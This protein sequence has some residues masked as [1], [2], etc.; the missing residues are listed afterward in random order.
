[1][2]EEVDVA[3]NPAVPVHCADLVRGIAETDEVCRAL[4]SDQPRAAVAGRV[5]RP[6]GT[7]TLRDV[8]AE[9]LRRAILYA[10]TG[11]ITV[12]AAEG[13]PGS[14]TP[15]AVRRALQTLEE[16]YL[17]LY[18]SPRLVINAD[19]FSKMARTD[20]GVCSGVLALTTNGRLISG[21]RDWWRR[22]HPD[23]RRY[24]DGAVQHDGVE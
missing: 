5:E 13:M 3:V 2:W 24:V 18:T 22:T 9:T 23:D 19:V 4:G 15:P 8:H 7:A 20:E 12:L 10:P 17:L 6:D 14:G 1:L 21:A 16:G 11:R